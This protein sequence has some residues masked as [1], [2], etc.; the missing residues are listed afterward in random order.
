M[1]ALEAS[2]KAR[3]RDVEGMSEASTKARETYVEGMSRQG[4]DLQIEP[5]KIQPITHNPKR[6]PRQTHI[7]DKICGQGHQNDS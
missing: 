4:F 1:D 3:Q 5:L 7:S 2:T 6:S